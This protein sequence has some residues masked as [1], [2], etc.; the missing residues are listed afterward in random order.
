MK[1]KAEVKNNVTK[2]NLPVL[3]RRVVGD[4][5]YPTL[6][7]DQLII[8]RPRAPLHVGDIIVFLYE[9]HEKIKR[10]HGIEGE[11]L[12]VLGDNP[13]FS[14]DSRHFGYVPRRTVLGK[15]AYP[16]TEKRIVSERFL[17]AERAKTKQK[18]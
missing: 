11:F 5:M 3:L 4:S 9:G 8:L 1:R 17:P 10:I 15:V 7:N 13:R 16:H 6:E 2:P 12:Y 14:T 18:K